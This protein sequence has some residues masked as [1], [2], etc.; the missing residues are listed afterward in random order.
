M[1]RSMIQLWLL[2][3]A[4]GA[5]DV[6]GF[7]G[8]GG[9]FAAHIT[10]NI[11]I[12]GAHFVTGQFST[13]GPLLSVPVF[14]LVLALVTM[15]GGKIEKKGFSPIAPLLLLQAIMLISSLTLGLIHGPFVNYDSALAVS[16]GML[17]VGAMATQ[18]AAIKMCLKKAP[19]T[20]AMTNNVT[21]MTIDL[22][23]LAGWHQGGAQEKESAKSQI[24]VVFASLFGFIIG[25]GCGALLQVK[26]GFGALLLPIVLAVVV[27]A[28]AF[29]KKT[30][31]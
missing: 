3:I 6:I 9:L 28:S 30:N 11:V 23:L 1:T 26:F 19:S 22:A 21:Q 7:L 20:V 27:V 12:L 8:L 5:V 24:K 16:T 10:G 15:I 14:M 2:S 17:A 18:S 31:T 25:C 29:N 13:T 4:A